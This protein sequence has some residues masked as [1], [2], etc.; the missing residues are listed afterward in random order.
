MIILTQCTYIHTYTHIYIN[1][2]SRV[3]VNVSTPKAAHPFLLTL[4]LFTCF[5]GASVPHSF[6]HPPCAPRRAFFTQM[7][8]DKNT[9]WWLPAIN[10]VLLQLRL[11]SYRADLMLERNGEKTKYI[12]DAQSILVRYYRNMIQDRS[13]VAVSK[14]MGCLFVIVHL[15]KIYFKLNNLRLCNNL[16]NSV[17][18]ASFPQFSSFPKSQTVS[19]NYYLGRL[20]VFE[21]QYDRA[22]ECLD[23]SFKHC[24]RD[25]LANKS[26]ILQFL[27]PVKLLLGK[28]PQERL[29][30]KYDLPQ[31]VGLIE[32]IKQG[33]LGQFN[34]NLE[35]HTTFFINKGIFLILEKLKTFVYRNLFRK[36]NKYNLTHQPSYAKKNQL[37]LN[38]LQAALRV[39]GTDMELN[40]LE[41]ILANL[42]FQ[43]SIKGY[44]AHKRCVVLSKTDPF[45][46]KSR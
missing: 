46:Q 21:E 35:K 6:I 2:H 13:A 22:E 28:F 37:Q 45:P 29:L 41:C 30:Q 31:F 34:S 19:Y 5:S 25:H 43:G 38:T 9:N 10:A 44:I 8:A 39:N 20:M 16:V 7:L 14:K 18:N 42:I 36:I 27:I 1:S 40:E 32:A 17:N 11:S 12:M 15:F 26:R 3:C 24:H 33:N 23:Y 4:H